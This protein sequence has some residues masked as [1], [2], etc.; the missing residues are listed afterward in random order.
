MGKVVSKYTLVFRAV[1]SVKTL[2]VTHDEYCF[3]ALCDK[4]NTVKIKPSILPCTALSML[5][6]TSVTKCPNCTLL[7]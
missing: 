3:F 5:N 2:V 6:Y 4:S 1:C 7:L